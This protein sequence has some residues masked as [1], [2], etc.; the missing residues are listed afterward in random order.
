VCDAPSAAQLLAVKPAVAALKTLVVF[1]HGAEDVKSDSVRILTFAD[2]ERAGAEHPHAPEPPTP[3]SMYSFVYTSGST[4]T[5]KGALITQA[6]ATA[7]VS[8]ILLNDQAVA[9]LEW[10]LGE[11]VHMSFLPM[12]H[13]LERTVQTLM[14]VTGGCVGFSQGVREKILDDIKAMRPTFF[15]CV[16]RLLNRIY[17]K[18]MSGV[19]EA[20]GAKE[21]V[22]NAALAAKLD[23]LK[24]GYISHPVWDMLV[25]NSIKQKLGFDR[26]RRVLTGSAPVA[27]AVLD[28]YRAAF[29]VLVAEGYGASETVCIATGTHAHS[30]TSEH[31]GAPSPCAEIRLVSAPTMGYLVTDSK[32]G[33]LDVLGRGEVCVRGNA[34]FS[35]YYRS[36]EQ[37]K[38]AI[39]AEGFYHTG[40]VGVML[41]NGTLKIVD[42]VRNIFK[43]SNGE[44]VAVEKVENCLSRCPLVAQAFVYGDSMHPK[45]VAV[46]VPDVDTAVPWAKARGLASSNLAEVCANATFMQAVLKEINDVGRKNGLLG[47]EIPA[48]IMLEP[49]AFSPDNILTPTFKIQRAVAKKHYAAQLEEML[50]RPE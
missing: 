39:D 22:F 16:P 42:R 26:L 34:V 30:F 23:G 45:L 18:I 28:F 14:I 11:E 4:G 8:G 20:G 27:G 40:D 46:V 12:A 33:E 47:F 15:P 2:V 36:P 9:G 48:N 10:R 6:A 17:D 38:A 43:L 24:E 3:K 41:P 7:N 29:G 50:G 19:R 32:H 21:I 35:E 5:P 37:T 44:Y 25:F 31:V 13:A 49:V 1:G